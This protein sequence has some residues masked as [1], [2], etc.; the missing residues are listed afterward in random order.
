[1]LIEYQAID[2]DVVSHSSPVSNETTA[3]LALTTNSPPKEVS[4]KETS[5]KNILISLLPSFLLCAV[6]WFG[7]TP[8]EELTVTAIHLLAVFT[9]CIFAL[10]TT[11]VDISMLVL[12]GL[13][14]LALTQSFECVDHATGT[15]TECR[16][17]G[18]INPLTGD[19]FQC[20]GGKESFK[21][22]LEGFSS[23]VVWLIFAAFHLGKA[24]E[25]TKLGQRLSFIMIK[26]FGKHNLGLAYAIIASELLLAPFV[27][28]NTARGGGIVLPVVQS[29]ATTLGST[30]ESHPEIGSFLILVGNHANL[31]SASM[32]LTGMAANPIVVAKANQ[33]FPNINFGFMVWLQGSIVPALVCAALIPILI[34]WS[35]G[36]NREEPKRGKHATGGNNV[37]L[38]A[39]ME[40]NKMGPMTTKEW[41]LCFTLV[42]CLCLWVMSN[43]IHLDSTLVALLGIVVLLHLGTISWK[44]VSGNTKAWDTLFWLGGFVTIAQHLS[45]AGASSFLG[46]KISYAIQHFNLPPLPSLAIA[47]FLTTFM[48]SSLSAHT[49]AFVSTFLDAGH[50][51]G[52]NPT[53]LIAFIA[54]FGNLG[55]CMTNF[56]TGMAAMYYAP[57]YV[58]RSKWFM[59]GFEMAIFYIFVYFTVGWTWWKF[60]GWE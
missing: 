21:Q 11:S 52:A 2:V 44:D 56:S 38:H 25:V 27:P 37:V 4:K 35:L 3:L 50:T 16:L 23:S 60:L 14:V 26:S 5:S 47:Y 7:V 55:G 9:S 49:V 19:L 33:L 46:H 42:G 32:Y 18:E 31:L 40:L 8:D 53:F 1:M 45:E 20:K 10:I 59:V 41:Q 17:C 57:G 39:K 24:V 29:I 30:P 22:S 12:T 58:A 43:V 54:Y 6:I 36:I 51:L 15:L 48:F 34:R 28:S 13:T